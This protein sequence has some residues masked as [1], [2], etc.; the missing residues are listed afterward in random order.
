[1][2]G[3]TDKAK[4]ELKNLLNDKVDNPLAGLRLIFDETKSMLALHIDIEEEGDVVFTHE[5]SKILIVK[6]AVANIL[7][8]FSIDVDESDKGKQLVIQKK[9]DWN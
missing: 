7:G 6:E 1:M 9:S 8:G 2:L 4:D 5:G 3:L